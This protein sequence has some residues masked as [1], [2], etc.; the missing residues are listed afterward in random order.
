[1][2]ANDVA[3]DLHDVSFEQDAVF[4][5]LH[6]VLFEQSIGLG[7]CDGVLSIPLTE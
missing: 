1:L 7:H 2:L 4:S 5:I 3:F 6:V